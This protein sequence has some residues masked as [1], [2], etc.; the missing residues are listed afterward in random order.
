MNIKH[1]SFIVLVFIAG[2]RV[3]VYAQENTVRI[4]FYNVENFFDP[5]DDSLTLDEEFTPSGQKH[6]TMDRFR[7]KANSLYK[8]FMAAGGWQPPAII[9]MAEVENSYVLHYLTRETPFA[10]FNYRYIHFESP[11]VRGIDVAVIY[12]PEDVKVLSAVPVSIPMAEGVRPTRDILFLKTSVRGMLLYLFVNHWPSRSGG[13]LATKPLR[14]AAAEKLRFCLDTLLKVH[15]EARVVVMGDF[16][17]E[18]DDE[19]LKIITHNPR[20]IGD[21]QILNLMAGMQEEYRGTLFFQ[22][23]WWTFDQFLV[24]DN[25]VHFSGG[26]M[27]LKGDAVVFNPQFLLTGDL[28]ARPWRTYNGFQYNGGFSDHLPVMITLVIEK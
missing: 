16:N 9:G 15:P 3:F 12:N 17:D 14:V 22:D 5:F 23:R 7:K 8:V 19:S 4:M 1:L 26:D 18:P 10:K 21:G 2:T 13:F 27:Y 24:S 25:L 6:W 20:N 11:D 28:P